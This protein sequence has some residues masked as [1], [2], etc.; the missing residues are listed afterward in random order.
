MLAYGIWSMDRNGHEVT[1]VPSRFGIRSTL[2]LRVL[3]DSAALYTLMLF[4][5]LV[6][7]A[8]ESTWQFIVLDMVRLPIR[9]IFEHTMILLPDNAYYINHLLHCPCSHCFREE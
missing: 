7:C 1:R 9:S 8:Y 3:V 2:V 5:L 4:V 6:C